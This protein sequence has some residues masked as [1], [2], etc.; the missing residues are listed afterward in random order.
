LYAIA[1]SLILTGRSSG[2][3]S[4]EKA[5]PLLGQVV[6]KFWATGKNPWQHLD[7]KHRALNIEFRRGGVQLFYLGNC[8]DIPEW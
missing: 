5:R 1:L 8:G 6:T 4:R 7:S 2:I 3:L